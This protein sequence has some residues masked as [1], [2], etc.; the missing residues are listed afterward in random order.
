M[1][2]GAARFVQRSYAAMLICIAA[3][4]ASTTVVV[5]ADCAM[6][7]GQCN[8]WAVTSARCRS[9]R[10]EAPAGTGTTVHKIVARLNDSASA[11]VASFAGWQANARSIPPCPMVFDPGERTD[12][13]E[14]KLFSGQVSDDCSAHTN[15]YTARAILE[16]T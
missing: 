7:S 1:M 11:P 2:L 4:F 13:K 5:A 12:N 6:V 16:S 3:L 10:R 9:I 8:S 15:K 14:A